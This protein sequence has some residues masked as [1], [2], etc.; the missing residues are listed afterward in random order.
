MTRNKLAFQSNES[1]RSPQCTEKVW[2]TGAKEHLSFLFQD[3][4]FLCLRAVMSPENMTSRSP[5][6]DV[7]FKKDSLSSTKPGNT[8]HKVSQG[9]FNLKNDP[10][11]MT[12]SWCYLVP[13][14]KASV[15]IWWRWWWFGHF[16]SW[17]SW[18]T[19]RPQIYKVSRPLHSLSMF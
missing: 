1:R 6:T 8:D 7:T 18:R 4:G 11:L 17:L 2:G 3:R 14:I 10:F 12:Q 5:P 16:L 9:L 13:S 19:Q 15:G